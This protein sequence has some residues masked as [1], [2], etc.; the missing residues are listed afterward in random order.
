MKKL[1]NTGWEAD[2][3]YRNT[4][5][6]TFTTPSR[7]IKLTGYRFKLAMIPSDA[8][9]IGG[10]AS[11]QVLWWCAMFGLESDPADD[12]GTVTFVDNATAKPA[13]AIAGLRWPRWRRLGAGATLA[14]AAQNLH[15]GANT[16][17]NIVA[18]SILKA[19]PW[20]SA[21]NDFLHES[22]WSVIVPPRCTVQMFAGHAGQGPIDF[23][24]QG[25]LLYE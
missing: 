13:A 5:T 10:Y 11:A 23:E 1:C 8:P 9:F 22:G 24:V 4:V 25:G 3:L 15:G 6:A 12:W 14:A 2:R 20:T 18:V 16:V 17:D 21:V 19:S 7:P